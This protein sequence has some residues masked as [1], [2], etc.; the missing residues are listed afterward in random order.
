LIPYIPLLRD[1]FKRLLIK[2]IDEADKNNHLGMKGIDDIA[3]RELKR[4][5]EDSFTKC[6]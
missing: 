3:W 1:D 4:I 2:E 6:E 5:L